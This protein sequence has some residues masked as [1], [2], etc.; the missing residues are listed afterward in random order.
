MSKWRLIREE[1]MSTIA[2]KNA[3][4]ISEMARMVGL[5][6]A[7]FYQLIGTTFPFPVY[8]I[9]TRRPF[10]SEELQM[11]CLE[12]RRRNCGIDGKPLMFYARRLAPS[13]PAKRSTLKH[14]P[15]RSCLVEGL[16]SL[17]LTP[18]TAQVE[19]AISELYPRGVESVAQGELLRAVFLHVKRQDRADNVGR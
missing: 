4:S 15:N 5:S 16:K 10:Y 2:T 14:T 19:A 1:F 9:A 13:V 11:V 18:T 6:R 7:R 8:D 17:G 3:V 12:V